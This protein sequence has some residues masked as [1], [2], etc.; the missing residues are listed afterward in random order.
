MEA[1]GRE[2]ENIDSYE[3]M[4]F[5]IKSTIIS[6]KHL[7]ASLHIRKLHIDLLMSNMTEVS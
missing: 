4:Y 5:L 3:N 1:A 7:L 2:L 6:M